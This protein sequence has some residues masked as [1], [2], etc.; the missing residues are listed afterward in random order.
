MKGHKEVGI[1][2]T[3]MFQAEK[4]ACAKAEKENEENAKGGKRMTWSLDY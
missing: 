4:T 1:A 3:A 2:V